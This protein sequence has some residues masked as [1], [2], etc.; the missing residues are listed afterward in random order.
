MVTP[1]ATEPTSSEGL[2]IK[3][4]REGRRLVTLLQR[5][6]ERERGIEEG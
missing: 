1:A 2:A 5:E 6:R 4:R 3:M